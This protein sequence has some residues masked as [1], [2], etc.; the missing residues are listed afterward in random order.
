ME[1]RKQSPPHVL[2]FPFPIQGHVNSM[3]KLAELLVLAGLKVTFI[4]SDHNHDRLVRFTDVVARFAKYPSFQFRTVPDGLPDDHPRSGDMVMEIFDGLIVKTKPALRDLLVDI[5]PPVDCIIGD[6]VLG[7]VLDIGQ[8]LKTPVIQFRT[9]SSCC[10]WVYYV[11]PDLI[12]A[13]L[14]PISGNEDMDRLVKV[15]PGMESF[16]RIRDLPSFCQTKNIEDSSLQTIAMATRKS[17]RAHAL[18]FNTFEDLEGPILSHI[19]TECPKI[20]TIGPL[21]AHLKTRL[22]EDQKNKAS[23]ESSNSLWAVDRS[24]MSWLDQQ[25]KQSVIYVSFG[26]IT[27][28]TRE[29]LLE[30]WYGLVNSKRRFLWIVRPDSVVGHGGQDIPQELIE[31]T[32]ERGYLIDWA[33]QEE[34]LAHWAIGGFL[35]HS[36]WNSTL[37]SLVAGVPMICWPYFADQQLNSRYVGEVW[38]LGLDM[39]DVCDRNVVERMINDIMEEK[40]EEFVKSARET[41]KLAKESVGVGGSSYCN[42]DRLIEDIRLKMKDRDGQEP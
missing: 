22:P 30:I 42:L 39:K 24:C 41:A 31:G 19:R 28:M 40:R 13:R 29:Q 36:G 38:K 6:G 1:D 20:Y 14:I 33:P 21:H 5:R 35:T 2:I 32:K 12:E 7:F 17:S 25:E 27:V 26:S 23:S 37:E 16:L 34:V 10:F 3:L 8:E 11:I 18:I 4:N 15:V 9:I